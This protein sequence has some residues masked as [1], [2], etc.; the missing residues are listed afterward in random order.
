MNDS[1]PRLL[2]GLLTT[3]IAVAL[4][5]SVAAYV[6]TQVVLP[7]FATVTTAIDATAVAV[8]P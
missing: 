6:Y 3:I 7:A 8:A 1:T 2:D 5:I 4:A